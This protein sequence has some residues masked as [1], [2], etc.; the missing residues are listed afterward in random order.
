VELVPLTAAQ[1]IRVCHV[2]FSVSGATNA[3]FIEG[4][5][6]SCAGA[7]ANLSGAYTNILGLAL[8][9]GD[10]TQFQTTVANGFCLTISA[11]VT[12]GGL[13]TYGKY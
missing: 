2:S 11:A 3:T 5:G 13:V 12:G 1:R 10:R 4:T 7:P 6:G 8:D 9:L